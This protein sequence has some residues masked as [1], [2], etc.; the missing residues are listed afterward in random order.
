MIKEYLKDYLVS[1]ACDGVTVM[2]GS[3]GGVKKLLK[4][5]FP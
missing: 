4:E 1:V 2:F 5:T 3:R